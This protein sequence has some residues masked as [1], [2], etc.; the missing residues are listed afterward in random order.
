MASAASASACTL[1]Q[2]TASTIEADVEA[3][4]LG[5]TPVAALKW[6]INRDVPHPLRDAVCF[7][8]ASR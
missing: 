6:R 3:V 2:Q 5:V 1:G 7:A 8:L 4:M